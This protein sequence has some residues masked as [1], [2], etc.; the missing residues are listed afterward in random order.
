MHR[1]P[2]RVCQ[3]NPL[4]TTR[5]VIAAGGALYQVNCA[6][7]HGNAGAGDGPAAAGMSPRPA[8]LRWTVQRPIATDGYLMWAMSDG[9]A[10]LGTGMPAFAGV[11]SEQERWQ[12]VLYLRTL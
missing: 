3:G 6:S 10:A 11:L 5:D 8:N 7:C 9:G 2:V 1:H 4:P 12:I